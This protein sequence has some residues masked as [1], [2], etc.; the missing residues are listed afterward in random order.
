R[1]NMYARVW[2]VSQTEK[3]YCSGQIS[4]TQKDKNDPSKYKTLFSGRVQFASTAKEK[5]LSMG[6]PQRSSKENPVYKTIKITSSPDIGYYF[7]SQKYA[8]ILNA[9]KD[10]GN[11]E[12]INFVKQN[13]VQKPITLWDFEYPVDNNGSSNATQ[14]EKSTT[15]SNSKSTK[16]DKEQESTTISD[17]DLPF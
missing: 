7:D 10:T 8:R 4:I 9:A 13:G 1:L 2:S 3:G 5:A 11:E 6:L 12:L 17:D 16:T 15:K 14:S